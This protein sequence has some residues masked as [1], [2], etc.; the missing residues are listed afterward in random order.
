MH[1]DDVKKNMQARYMSLL[2]ERDQFVT[3]AN[4]K[5][6]EYAGRLAELEALFHQLTEAHEHPSGWDS[7]PVPVEPLQSEQSVMD[8]QS[9]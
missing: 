3:Q 8:A 1:N 9:K 4:Q 5:L 7:A 2:A 6:G